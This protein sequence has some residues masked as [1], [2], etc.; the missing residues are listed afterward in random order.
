MKRIYL[1]GV[2]LLF[3]SQRVFSQTETATPLLVL[4]TGHSEGVSSLALNSSGTLLAT[5]GADRAIKL[6]DA[7]SGELIRTYTGS[8]SLINSLVFADDSQSLLSLDALGKLIKLDI[9]TGSSDLL[10]EVSREEMPFSEIQDDGSFVG[11]GAGSPSSLLEVIPPAKSKQ[12]SVMIPIPPH[13]TVAAYSF[14]SQMGATASE[15]GRVR[16]WLHTPATERLLPGKLNDPIF[17]QFSP[18]GRFLAGTDGSQSIT[19]WDTKSFLQ[20]FSRSCAQL[21]GHKPDQYNICQVKFVP[22]Q[23]EVAV[24]FIDKIAILDASSGRVIERTPQIPSAGQIAMSQ[25][26][27]LLYMLTGTGF[28][29]WNRQ[30]SRIVFSEEAPQS[31]VTAVAIDPAA[32]HLL[33]AGMRSGDSMIVW[34]LQKGRPLSMSPNSNGLFTSAI[35]SSADVFARIDN[36]ADTNP[37]QVWDG[38]S[39]IRKVE[40]ADLTPATALAVGKDGGTIAVGGGNYTKSHN[41]IW[42]ISADAKPCRL[43]GSE[44]S[45]WNLRFSHDGSLLAS[46]SG[47]PTK[48]EGGLRLWDIGR[49]SLKKTLLGPEEP[50][51]AVAFSPDDR[52]LATS[53]A[54]IRVWDVA[55]QSVLQTLNAPDEFTGAL[56]FRGPKSGEIVTGSVSGTV[57]IWDWDNQKLLASFEAHASQIYALALAQNGTILAS[58]AE[59]GSVK[60]WRL[61]SDQG[62]PKDVLKATELATLFASSDGEW[63]IVAPDG[64]FDTNQLD[65]ISVM[66]WIFPEE[67]LHPLSPEVFMRQYYTPNLLGH[68]L[69]PK[70]SLGEKINYKSFAELNRSQ[71]SVHIIEVQPEKGDPA[72]VSVTVEVSGRN[73]TV[74]RD[75]SGQL[76]ASGDYDLRLFRDGQRVGQ[77][78]AEIEDETAPNISEN[79][80]PAWRKNHG[81]ELNTSGKATITF[82]HVLLPKRSAMGKVEFTAYAFNQDRVKSQSSDP[83]EYKLPVVPGRLPLRRAYLVTMGVNANQ[84]PNLNLDLAVSSAEKARAIL[85]DKLRSDYEEVIEIPLYSELDATSDQIRLKSASKSDLR[86]VLDLLAG[87]VVAPDVREEVDPSHCLQAATPDDAVVLYIASH[88]YADSQGTFY[89]Q[90][91]DTGVGNWGV[92]EETLAGCEVASASTLACLKA[93]SFLAHSISSWELSRWWNGVD[94]GEMVMLLD[95]CHSGAV[96]GKTFRPGPL[97]DPGFGQLSYDKRMQILSASQPNKTEHGVWVTGDEGRTLMVDALA[98]VANSFPQKRL[99]EWLAETEQQLSTTAQRLYPTLNDEN[100]PTPLLFDFRKGANRVTLITP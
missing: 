87:R 15:E 62:G 4:N 17:L 29:V 69:D 2:L 70:Y 61:S 11:I 3:L 86:T 94:A 32:R 14:I 47:F 40:A 41:D 19:V 84:S 53:G 59:D 49:C 91:Y 5:G 60:L 23:N 27:R 89:L 48:R 33:T 98:T 82:P 37:V 1:P 22:H 44:L 18:D 45:I 88:G 90:P 42:V 30:K 97:G 8:S 58:G 79:Y 12:H 26:G 66:H 43:E 77:W 36:S 93:K 35:S 20:L 7:H 51:N 78:P 99:E 64:Q 63:A 100:A 24:G 28:T 92:T 65:R 21:V 73:S 10:H 13:Q 75:P 67:P 74:Q 55:T 52:L 85:R 9:V 71:P 56:A 95:S 76:L 16:L 39:G 83:Y 50:T 34:D 38:R 57:R 72:R 25:D 68:L 80:M 31:T 6:W 46:G 81:I 96:S 54:R